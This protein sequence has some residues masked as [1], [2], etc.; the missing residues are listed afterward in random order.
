MKSDFSDESDYV[1]LDT[2]KTLKKQHSEVRNLLSQDMQKSF[3]LLIKESENGDSLSEEK[4]T[5]GLD[6][7]DRQVSFE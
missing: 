2:H 4:Y 6:Q 1:N 5:N 7:N 3:D